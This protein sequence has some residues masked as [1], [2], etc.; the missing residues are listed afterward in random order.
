MGHTPFGP[1]STCK[2]LS[3]LAKQAALRNALLGRLEKQL[4]RLKE[5][6]TE[7]DVFIQE[8]ASVFPASGNQS[9]ELQRD[10]NL[11]DLLYT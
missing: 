3:L 7:L 1:Y 10:S 2:T 9:Q 6:V 11:I 8:Y 5:S 4:R